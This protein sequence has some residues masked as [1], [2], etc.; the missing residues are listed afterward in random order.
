MSGKLVAG[1]VL[2]GL[3]RLSHA[4]EQ[5][6]TVEVADPLAY[7]RI[8]ADTEGNSHFSS[9]Q[10]PFSLIEFSPDLAPVSGANPMDVTNLVVLPAP[11]GGVADWHPVPRR[12]VNIILAGEVE[13]EVS[14]GEVR[15]FGPGSF[16]LG[17][18]T[19]GTGHITRVVSD[20]D[21]YF[22]VVA[23]PDS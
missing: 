21:T 19:A 1:V 17:E 14:D 2:L 6:A 7:A 23:L 18:D 4:Q 8:Y 22:A 10:M 11:A 5:E 20:V 3:A 13:V 15:R 12:Q 16:M 9:E